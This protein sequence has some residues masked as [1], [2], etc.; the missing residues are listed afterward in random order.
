MTEQLTRRAFIRKTGLFAGAVAGATIVPRHVLGGPRQTA[1]SEKMN[2]AGV[3]VGGMGAAAWRRTGR[4][5]D[6]WIPMGNDKSQ[7]PEAIE[8][9]R[10]AA[11]AAGRGDVP[12]AVGYMAFCFGDL[13]DDSTMNGF[14]ADLRAA[15]EVG[16]NTF[17]L[18]FRGDDVDAYVAQLELFAERVVPLV[19]EG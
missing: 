9:M 16:A 8:T 3:G 13:A 2:V 15:R 4:I 11:D 10:A 12:L 17:H 14:A 6:G 19:E 7:Y 18:M 1:P 5:G